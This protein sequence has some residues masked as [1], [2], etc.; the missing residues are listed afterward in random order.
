[1]QLKTQH[2]VQS[3]N[4]IDFSTLLASCIHDIKN[5]LGLLI[6]GMN[7]VSKKTADDNSRTELEQ[8]QFQS[9][10]INSRLIQLLVLYRIDQSQ[11]YPHTTETDIKALLE[12]SIDPYHQLFIQKQ[13]TCSI[14]CAEDLYWYI[15]SELINGALGNI[16]HNLYQYTQSKIEITVQINDQML[17][18]QVKDDGPGYPENTLHSS[19]HHHKKFS[20]KSSNTGLGLYFVEIAAE[21]HQNY[22]KKG[23]IVI[24]NDGIHNGGCITITLP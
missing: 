13:I 1:M 24:T 23:H 8:L 19:S 4:A 3:T 17:V 18:I 2:S 16:L 9:E 5:G 10:Y 22:G 20:F 14:V 15:D 7:D 12:E 11:Y 21:M 6:N